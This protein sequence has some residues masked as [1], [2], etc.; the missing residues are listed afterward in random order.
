MPI[1][2]NLPHAE[3]DRR[4]PF[5]PNPNCL[6]EIKRCEGRCQKKKKSHI[7]LLLSPHITMFW[8]KKHFEFKDIPDLSGKTAIITGANTGVSSGITPQTRT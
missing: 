3:I 4:Q 1:F 2:R 8:S 5:F 7:F 6:G